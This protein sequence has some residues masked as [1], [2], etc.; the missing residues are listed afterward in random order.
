MLRQEGLKSYFP[1]LRI[2][3]YLC[4]WS[5]VIFVTSISDTKTSIRHSSVKK[6]LLL[7]LSV[8][9][10]KKLLKWLSVC[11][12]SKK[13]NFKITFL[14][15]A[16]S[17]LNIY[18]N[19]SEFFSIVVDASYLIVIQICK[20]SEVWEMIA[21]TDWVSFVCELQPTSIAWPSPTPV[22]T[23]KPTIISTIH[24]LNIPTPCGVQR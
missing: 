6:H 1:S 18:T 5:G 15:N 14:L 10:K 16:V 2:V 8:S 7:V 21:L 11:H 4:F 12:A 20:N 9:E 24:N 17:K 3:C 23:G 19:K 13:A 22:R